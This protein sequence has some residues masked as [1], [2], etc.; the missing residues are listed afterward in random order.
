MSPGAPAIRTLADLAAVAGVGD[1]ALALLRPRHAPHEY[2]SAL[3]AAGH[4]PDA[5]R[6]LAHA[7]PRREGVWWAWATAKRAI[8]AEPGAP[9]AAVLDATERWIGQ[10]SEEHR[11]A[12]LAAAEAAGLDTPAGGAGMAAFLSGPS[13]APPHIEQPVPPPEY[14][15]AKAIAGTV[16]MSAVVTQPGQMVEKLHA[17]LL[18]GLDVVDKI[19]LWPAM[20]AL[21][22]AAPAATES[23]AP[24]APPAKARKTRKKRTVE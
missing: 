15:A 12:A 11:H 19:K 24:E 8:G 9:A 5:V 16:L 18:Q 4:Y 6:L 23:D 1:E 2:L 20:T 7:L 14:G 22:L 3:T 13:L 10:P 21:E 17:A